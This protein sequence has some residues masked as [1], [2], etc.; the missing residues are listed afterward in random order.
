MNDSPTT[1]LAQPVT[2]SVVR[3]RRR[4]GMW[5]IVAALLVA[6]PFIAVAVFFLILVPMF[7]PEVDPNLKGP[8]IEQP[9]QAATAASKNPEQPELRNCLTDYLYESANQQHE[10]PLDPA[11][12]VARQ[13]LNK[14]RS[15]IRDYT[16]Q[17]VKQERIG[18]KLGEEQFMEIK[19]RNPKPDEEIAMAVY[20]NF[21][22]PADVAGR[23]VIWVENKNRGRL[24]AHEGGLKSFMGGS[25][26]PNG[27][28]AMMGQ[29]Y[30]ITEMGIEILVSRL[31]EKGERDRA[32]SECE[33]E[34]SRDI[35][36]DGRPCTLIT[37]T[38]PERR[39]HFDFHIAK[40]YIDD[41]LDLPVGYEAYS[42]PQEPGGGPMLLEKYFYREIQL[43]AG[44]NERDFHPDN[45]NYNFR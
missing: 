23:E 10:H 11:L 20:L 26:N 12:H 21:L 39:D 17:M 2:D 37:I 6:I 29:R 18:G 32:H 13:S 30:P 1:Q 33:V 43:N 5:L 45:P 25:F 40:V 28:I 34:F 31:I 16:A 42:W 9:S 14:I 3:P 19:I 38:H 36:L 22:K 15:E 41:Q 35:E 4:V 24:M 44:L 8:Q 27:V 7:Q